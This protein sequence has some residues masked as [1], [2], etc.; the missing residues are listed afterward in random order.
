MSIANLLANRRARSRGASTLRPRRTMLFVEPLEARVLLA[1]PTN[2]TQTRREQ[3]R[4]KGR[5]PLTRRTLSVFLR[6]GS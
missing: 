4:P 3:V 1:V 2:I 5:L 6:P